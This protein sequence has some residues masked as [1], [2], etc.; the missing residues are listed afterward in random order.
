[1]FALI[2]GLVIFLGLHSTRIVAEGAR[3]RFIAERGEGAWKGLYSVLSVIGLVLIVWG[4]GIARDEAEQLFVE[5]GWARGLQFLAMPVALFLVVASQFPAGYA[6]RALGHPMLW[7]VGVWSLGHLMA[8]GDT[9]SVLLFGAF[10]VWG[11]FDLVS[12]YR[13]PRANPHA[14]G[15][16]FG[17]RRWPDVASAAIAIVLTWAFMAFLHE[18]LFGVA[19]IG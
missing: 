17:T 5:P 9:A 1:M 10:L 14:Q 4:Y 12:C 16:G 18:W 11:A 7:G 6:K 15:E 19:L 13:H 3:T 2:L 8:N